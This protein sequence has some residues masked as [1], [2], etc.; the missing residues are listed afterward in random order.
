MAVAKRGL[1][2]RID[3]WT[4]SC[5]TNKTAIQALSLV[6]LEEPLE[7]RS[8]F[9]EPSFCLIAQGAKRL[10]LGKESFVY[11]DNHFL[12][13]AMDLPVS[14]QILEA[15]KE[16]PYLSLMLKI[17]QKAISQL[18][19]DCD[20][21]SSKKSQPNR[22]VHVS[23]LALPLLT[24]LTRL[25][26]LLDEPDSIPILSPLI[27]REILYRLLASEHGPFL[28][29][30]GAAGSQGFQVS[31]AID[32][33]K[34]NFTKQLRIDDLASYCQMSASSL[35]HH[36][37]TMTSMSPLQYQ[38]LLRLQEARR[39]ML[40]ESY[41]AASAA[42]HVGYESPSQF[43]REYRRLF[44]DSPVRDVKALLNAGGNERHSA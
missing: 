37:R 40:A 43:S 38:K 29:Q 35:H 9:Q 7:A 36:F 34:H 42:F 30:I 24:T 8:Y 4:P 44:N 13:T 26:D 14:A 2:S 19:V 20:F 23:E 5:G 39:L 10:F 16:R 28:R 18:M 12:I 33:M 41:D 22:S 15:S 31:R 6:R 25:I 3:R 11:D 17:D 1:L 32:W 27:Q 21:P